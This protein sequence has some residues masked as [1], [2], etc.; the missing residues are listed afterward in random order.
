MFRSV[1]ARVIRKEPE[2]CL[3]SAIVMTEIGG[4]VMM[5]SWEK[6]WREKCIDHRSLIEEFE[7]EYES[8]VLYRQ[9]SWNLSAADARESVNS[10]WVWKRGWK[11][12]S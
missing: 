4:Y 10:D 11:P 5:K 6:K 2:M 8:E 7:F 12:N 3:T 9:M 1:V